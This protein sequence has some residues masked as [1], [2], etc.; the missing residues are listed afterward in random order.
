[1]TAPVAHPDGGYGFVP[2]IAPYSAG[3]RADAGHRIRHVTLRH[4]LPWRDGFETIDRVLAAADRPSRSLCS[5]E[6]RCPQP[7]SFGGFGTFN[8]DYRAALDERNILLDGG[9]NPIARTNVAPIGDRPSDTVLHAFGFTV[10]EAS[11][12]HPSFVISGAG[13]LRDQADLRAEAIVA[14]DAPWEVSGPERTSVVLDEIEQRM[15]GLGLDWADT[16]VVGVY[17][18]EAIHTVLESVLLDRLGAAAGRGLTWY[19]SQPPITG[20][21]YEMDARGG[22]EPIWL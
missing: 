21:R 14:G 3:V 4:P 13:D 9:V 5:I 11:G 22:V 19:P 15:R 16:D 17:S 2:G 1:M 6:L 7:H 12:D 20:L 10:P 8:D 18:V